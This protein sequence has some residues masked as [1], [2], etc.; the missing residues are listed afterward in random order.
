MA[1]HDPITE[2][3]LVFTFDA[4]WTLV[5]KWDD[6]AA[7]KHGL[8]PELSPSP[9]KCSAWHYNSES[10]PFADQLPVSP[11]EGLIEIYVPRT[12]SRKWSCSQR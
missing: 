3:D 4:E 11:R 12:D 1:A 9:A 8:P 6:T 2:G 10:P 7:F 5:L